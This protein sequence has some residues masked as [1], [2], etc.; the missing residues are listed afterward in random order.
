ME[1]RRNAANSLERALKI[2]EDIALKIKY[3]Y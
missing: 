2:L 3:L 1:A